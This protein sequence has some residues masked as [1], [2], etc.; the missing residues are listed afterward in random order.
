MT[1]FF[2]RL[3]HHPW[4]I[5]LGTT[6]LAAGIIMLQHHVRVVMDPE[7]TEEARTEAGY[8]LAGDC[9]L[10]V[11]G[12]LA[13]GH[14]VN[15]ALNEWREQ[16]AAAGGHG[17]GGDGLGHDGGGHDGGGHD[18][19]GHDGGD[20]DGGH[21]GGDHEMIDMEEG[22]GQGGDG[23]AQRLDQ[24]VT[25]SATSIGTLTARL[26]QENGTLPQLQI[27]ASTSPSE[28]DSGQQ[29]VQR[30]QP[31]VSL[32][33]PPTVPGQGGPAQAG[34]AQPTD[35]SPL[36]SDSDTDTE[37]ELINRRAERLAERLAQTPTVSV[38]AQTPTVSISAPADEPKDTPVL[39]T[40]HSSESNSESSSESSSESES[41]P[42]QQVPVGAPSPGQ[43]TT[44]PGQTTTPPPTGQG[45]DTA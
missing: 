21:D 43:T 27:I 13:Y 22:Y 12:L 36:V 42:L 38:S 32:S 4:A 16:H 26:D 19:G 23:N 7:S 9:A 33:A 29:A 18:G 3:V 15:N 8:A 44:P 2:G 1:G 37:E 24:A 25:N 30:G 31:A 11:S 40:H 17:G 41:P 35:H 28:S 10:V 39:V 45:G 34:P 14:A 6:G 5:G 20:H